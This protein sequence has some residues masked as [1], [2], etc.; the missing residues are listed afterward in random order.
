MRI[1]RQSHRHQSIKQGI[2]PF[3]ALLERIKEPAD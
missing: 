3:V 2:L 1:G